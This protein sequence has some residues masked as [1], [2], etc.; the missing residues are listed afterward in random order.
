MFLCQRFF[1]WVCVW[2][3][4]CGMDLQSIWLLFGFLIEIFC[5]WLCFVCDEDFFGLVD[6]VLGGV[7]E[8]ECM[9]FGFLWMDVLEDELLS[10]MVWF[11][12]SFCNCVVLYDWMVVFVVYEGEWIIGVQ[13]FVVYGFL[14]CYIVNI[15]FWFICFV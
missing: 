3:Y 9:L 1:C 15:G 4:G 13:D 10:N 12:W 6:V 7:Y 2:W 8:L 14:D 5:L 11:Y